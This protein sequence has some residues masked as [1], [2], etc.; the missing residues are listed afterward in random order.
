MGKS[1]LVSICILCYNHEKFIAKV[2]DGILEQ[3]A[4]FDFK[5][6]IHDDCSKD[7]SL[8]IIDEYQNREGAKIELFRNNENKGQKECVFN[9]LHQ[10]KGK[11]IVLMDGDDYWIYKHK[12]QYQIDFLE[13]NLDYVA[14]CHD[15]RIENHELEETRI[16]SI[17][18]KSFYKTI[19]QF[20][21]YSSSQI[22][23]Y[24]LL[25]G[26]SYIQNSTLV[27]R[28]FDLSS[29]MERIKDVQ[30]NLDWYL[31]VILASKGKIN[32]IN[33]IWSVYSDHSGGRTKNNYFHS[34]LPD[35]VKLIKTLFK[36]DFYNQLY[37]RYIL[38]DLIAK[39]Y[40]G[41]IV[42]TSGYKKTKRFLFIT[43]LKYAR[44]NLLKICAF[45]YYVLRFRNNF[46]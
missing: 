36:I 28:R 31:G 20:T 8:K 33:E 1:E 23:A 10:A 32:Y 14:S 24:E 42:M 5:I 39:E 21:K 37:F 41:L 25:R 34:Y 19:S 6:Y 45:L 40:Y 13:K 27:W 17:Q 22:Q 46:H 43:S 30:F 29:N 12:L 9:L 44:Y 2:L 26:E 38:Y 3:E 35:K 15:A 18:S 11:Y 4:S 7:N 16:S